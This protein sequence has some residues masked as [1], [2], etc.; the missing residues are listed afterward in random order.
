MTSATGALG[1]TCIAVPVRRLTEFPSRNAVA[2]AFDLRGG[3][4]ADVDRPRLSAAADQCQSRGRTE[5]GSLAHTHG[6]SPSA[7]LNPHNPGDCPSPRPTPVFWIQP[8]GQV[9]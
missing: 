3:L 2:E 6:C 5:S 9:T 1:R 7:G 4:L 8:S